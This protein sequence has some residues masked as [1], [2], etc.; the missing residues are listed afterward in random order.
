ML[1][2]SKKGA[3]VMGSIVSFASLLTVLLTRPLSQ[4][5]AGNSG[6]G[7]ELFDQLAHRG[8]SGIFLIIGI[9]LVILLWRIG[10]AA[11]IIYWLDERHYG[12]QGAIRWIIF[13][14]IQSLVHEALLPH[15]SD[16]VLFMPRELVDDVLSFF[17]LLLVYGLV[18]RLFPSA[19][20]KQ[21]ASST[22]P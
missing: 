4:Y 3:I 15:I 12:V 18:F 2:R 22:D 21:E 16:G 13:G 10:V 20:Q 9:M 5:L 8:T 6:I 1:T 14:V 19:Y 17:L 11:F 7:I